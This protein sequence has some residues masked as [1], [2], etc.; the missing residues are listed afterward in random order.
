MENFKVYIGYVVKAVIFL[1]LLTTFCV[2]FLRPV[3]TQY[4]EKYT[5]IERIF[6]FRK[7][8]CSSIWRNDKNISLFSQKHTFTSSFTFQFGLFVFFFH[9]VLYLLTLLKYT[10]ELRFGIYDLPFYKQKDSAEKKT[11][12]E[13]KWHHL[14][15]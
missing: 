15:N 8:K 3:M 4:S 2:L 1:A 9:Q 6:K 13:K 11:Q 7:I 10:V 5:N 14:G 12:A